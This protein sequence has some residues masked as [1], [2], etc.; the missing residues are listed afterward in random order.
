MRPNRLRHA[1]GYR[2]GAA[3]YIQHGKSWPQQFRKAKVVAL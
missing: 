1:G 3:A 2:A